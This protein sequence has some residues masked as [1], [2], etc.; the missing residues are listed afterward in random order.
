MDY[1]SQPTF[2]E[3]LADKLPVSPTIISM[4]IIALIPILAWVC[5]FQSQHAEK[6][7]YVV[8]TFLAG[9][10][11][12]IPIKLYERYW[13]IAIFNLENI[14]L[15]HHIEQLTHIP[16]IDTFLAYI[17]AFVV[18]SV[19]LFLF[20]AMMMFV[21]EVLSGDNTAKVFEKKIV[22][23]VEEPMLFIMIG[24]FFGIAAFMLN[25]RLGQA[26][27]FFVIVGALEEFVKH[28]ITRF[29]DEFKLK[30]IADAI[31]F[32]IIVALGFAF[33]ENILYFLDIWEGSGYGSRELMLYVIL[34]ST[35]SVT[36]HVCFS[37]ILGY[38]Y[39]LAHF[40]SSVYQEE[41]RKRKHPVIQFFHSV[42][43][44]KSSTVFK[45]EKMLEGMLLAMIIHACFNMLLEVEQM[46]GVILLLGT[47]FL[48]IINLLHRTQ[49]HRR[50]GTVV[51]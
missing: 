2:W 9:M 19:A 46:T 15:F 12:I 28:L 27:W 44:L 23:I 32:S 43:H 11:S 42:F 10:L 5:F 34:R 33:V 30:S 38:Y 35:V 22:K 7:S 48:I 41:R 26:V 50:T 37:A 17:L 14:N 24:V 18:V 13:D 16:N 31:Q 20:V 6:K 47:L 29:S 3:F 45:E 40:S 8:L 21:L 25:L 4:G 36:A 1:S 51:A 49:V 39:G